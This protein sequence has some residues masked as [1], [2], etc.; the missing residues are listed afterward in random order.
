MSVHLSIDYIP[1]YFLNFKV[2]WFDLDV[3][4]MLYKT[5]KYHTK[6]VQKV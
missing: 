3:S 6:D 5:L 4:V 1:H 2:V